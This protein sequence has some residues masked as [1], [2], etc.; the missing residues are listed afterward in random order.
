MEGI[1]K[2]REDSFLLE[3]Y[4]KKYAKGIVLDLGTGSGIQAKAASSKA[5][6]VIAVDINQK[7]LEHCS[8]D[9]KSDKILC[10]KSDLFS[11]FEKNLN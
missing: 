5:D 11:F 8:K 10:L 7:A 3:K 6:F 9:L 2:P 4:V 1:Y